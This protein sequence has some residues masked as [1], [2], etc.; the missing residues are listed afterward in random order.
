[1]IMTS[2]PKRLRTNH[3]VLVS[4]EFRR[5]AAG[6]GYARIIQWRRGSRYMSVQGQY[7]RIAADRYIVVSARGSLDQAKDSASRDR[8]VGCRGIPGM[9][10]DL[11][12]RRCICAQN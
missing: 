9:R 8:G 7:N 1:M 10:R 6:D 4:P 2:E 5:G 11:A 3:E 12:G